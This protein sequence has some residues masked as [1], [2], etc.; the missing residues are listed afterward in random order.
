MNRALYLIVALFFCFLSCGWAEEDTYRGKVVVLEVGQDAL[1]SSQSFAYMS[2]VLKKAQKEGAAAVVFDL[3]TPGGLA[4]ETSELMLKEIEPLTIPTIAFV[5]NKAMSAGALIAATCDVIYMAPLSSIG[6]AGLVS[7]SGQEIDPR[8]RKK[9]E[10][11][12]GSVVRAVVTE[13]GHNPPVLEAMMI[14][15]EQEDT[16]GGVVL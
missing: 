9:L 16:F 8:M 13:N 4:W 11:A 12:F 2:R 10:S 5:N 1:A 7:G 14:P 15:V 6:A 3:N